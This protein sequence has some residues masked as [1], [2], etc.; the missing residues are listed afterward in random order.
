MCGTCGAY[1]T[2]VNYKLGT[3]LRNNKNKVYT[4][5]CDDWVETTKQQPKRLLI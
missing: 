1:K 4:Q 3:C 5:T 2:F